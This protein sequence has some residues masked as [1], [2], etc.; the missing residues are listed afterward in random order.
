MSEYLIFAV[1]CI[2]CLEVLDKIVWLFLH[3]DIDTAFLQADT[4][5]IFRTVQQSLLVLRRRSGHI[6]QLAAND[7]DE[8]LVG[9]I[10]IGLLEFILN[11]LHHFVA[12]ATKLKQ[13]LELLQIELVWEVWIVAFKRLHN[14][15]DT[16]TVWG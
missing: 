11:F 7:S 15:P 13:A 5:R 14:L 16:V 10:S 6:L 3:V 12:E 9:E 4:T 2:E 8:L 1:L